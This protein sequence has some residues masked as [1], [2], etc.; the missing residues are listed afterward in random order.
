MLSPT[1]LARFDSRIRRCATLL[2]P[3]ATVALYSGG[4]QFFLDRF[5]A[6]PPRR[7]VTPPAALACSPWGLEFR[8]PLLNA[9]GMF[10]KG[11]GYEVTAAQ[12]AGAYLAGTTTRTPRKGNLKNGIRAP[13][14][15]YPRSGAAS[16]WLGLPNPGH[17]A[18]AARMAKLEPIPGFPRGASLA[19]DSGPRAENVLEGLIEGLEAYHEAGVD[20]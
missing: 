9:A 8:S 17:R 5:A 14:A 1:L 18:V 16:N 7:P 3:L 6:S 20:F 12:G 13:F 2:P 15:P 11:E 19:V 4:R 10:K